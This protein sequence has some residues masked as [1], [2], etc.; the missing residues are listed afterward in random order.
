MFSESR[1]FQNFKRRCTSRHALVVLQKQQHSEDKTDFGRY[2]TEGLPEMSVSLSSIFLD[3]HSLEEEWRTF[4]PAMG[5]LTP[6]PRIR[7][8]NF[9]MEKPTCRNYF[10]G[11]ET[12]W[13]FASTLL[14]HRPTRA[15]GDLHRGWLSHPS[16]LALRTSVL[17]TRNITGSAGCARES[18]WNIFRQ[19]GDSGFNAISGG[20]F[21][22]KSRNR[23]KRSR[24]LFEDL[25]IFSCWVSRYYLALNVNRKRCFIQPL[26]DQMLPVL[27]S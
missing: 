24:I 17:S 23:V 13:V 7:E 4:L 21:A 11:R 1:K 6:T 5:S 2:R 26:G 25:L 20:E 12:S 8:S 16:S 27:P 19:L 15:G 9:L 18:P 3:L 10:S 22:E 14:A